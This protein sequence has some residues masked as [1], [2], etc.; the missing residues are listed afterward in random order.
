M[1][2]RPRARRTGTLLRYAPARPGERLGH[3]VVRCT[4]PD[5][6]RPIFHLDPSPPSPVARAAA[7]VTAEGISEKLWREGLG[8]T[9]RRER[10]AR[11]NPGEAD[12]WFEAWLA[13]RKRRGLN[14]HAGADVRVH[15]RPALPGHPRDWTPEDLRA[16]CRA[17]DAKV[18]AGELAWKTAVNVW[19]TATRI[20][21]DACA[22]KVE[23]LRVRDDN[24]A[25]GVR[26]PDRGVRKA[27]Q[28]L[29]PSEFLRFAAC[30]EVPLV[31]RRAVALAIYLYPRAAELRGLSLADDVDLEHGTVHIHRSLDG[32]GTPKPTKSKC[33]RRFAIEP[34]L[35]PLLAALRAEG[36][37]TV[38]MPAVQQSL[39]QCLRRELKRAGVD[40]AERH[41]R[42]ATS[43]PITF[44]DLR[45]TG[46][47]WAAVRGDDALKIMQ[48]AGH[49][50][51]PTTLRYI[52]TAEAVRAGFGDVF[53]PLPKCLL[54]AAPPPRG[55]RTR[56]PA[57]A[58][59]PPAPAT[60][61]VTRGAKPPKPLC[62]GE[63]LNHPSLA[64]TGT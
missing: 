48:R 49:E 50:N 18:Q 13:D 55:G 22:S 7:L 27:K 10:Q 26:G 21:R 30:P 40:R 45:A 47:T 17:L 57:P 42:T 14:A 59:A 25:A 56:A 52:R 23:A 16:L 62:S 2:A 1:P 54:G 8:A 28:F 58:P 6:T 64:A 15:I 41:R 24:P 60:G 63:D 11:A 20:C 35:V 33:P 9:P 61:A 12:A 4:A 31:W 43:L 19:G 38:K 37:A 51:Y 3:F 36:T 46:I 5:G 34:A 32:V 29:Y 39:S 53:P 44:H